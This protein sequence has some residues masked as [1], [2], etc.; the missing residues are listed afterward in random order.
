[1]LM[2]TGG[3]DWPLPA[4][5]VLVGCGWLLLATYCAVYTGAFAS[6]ASCLFRVFS[7]SARR[8]SPVR[9][10]GRSCILL[11]LLP[12]VWVGWEYLRSELLTG[13]PWNGLGVSQYAHTFLIQIADF[14]GVYAVSACIMAINTAIALALE[15]LVLAS[16]GQTRRRLTLELAVT[17]LALVGIITYGHRA[18]QHEAAA[19]PEREAMIVVGAVQPNVP[20]TRKLAPEFARAIYDTLWERTQLAAR[21]R[22]D[23]IVWPETAV[24]DL[25][26]QQTG[27]VAFIRLLAQESTALLVGAMEDAGGW[28]GDPSI[29]RY[30]NSAFLFD[31]H[32]T[33]RGRYR[34]R[35]LVPFGEYLPLDNHLRW[36]AA[37]A[38]LGFGCEPGRTPTVLELPESR[39]SSPPSPRRRFGVLIC[40][41]DVFAY[42]AR[43]LVRAGAQ[44]LVNQTNDAWFDGTSA[45]VQHMA[46]CVFRCVENRVPAVRVANTGVTCAI[47]SLGRLDAGT[48]QAIRD[49]TTH[50]QTFRSFSLRLGSPGAGRTLYSRYGDRT[51]AL[52][53]AGLTLGLSAI[54]LARRR[55]RH[56]P[57]PPT[58]PSALLNVSPEKPKR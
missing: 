46:H 52:P 54:F 47:D 22:P 57:L 56:A 39:P 20:Q 23:L 50:L 48:R 11:L 43:D 26:P 53:C 24:P 58:S 31:S 1:M 38:P 18:A 16:A 41:E 19:R 35:H 40:F 27:T 34:K 28:R 36:L 3:P 51:L 17:A 2:R 12:A 13:F 25:V 42:L 21:M 33:M 29:P 7:L 6:V 4:V 14:G 45:A 55:T 9:D 32:G 10:V 49:G 37:C 5:A 8:R 44:F 15:H 30:Y